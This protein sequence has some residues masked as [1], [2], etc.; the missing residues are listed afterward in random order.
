MFLINSEG[1][2]RSKTNCRIPGG[3]T[4]RP[5][6]EGNP[7]IRSRFKLRINYSLNI[8]DQRRSDIK[9]GE[10]WDEMGY[11]E[12]GCRA[13]GSKVPSTRCRTGL[14]EV[15]RM[16]TPMSV[17]G[18]MPKT[19][20]PKEMLQLRGARRG[21][22]AMGRAREDGRAPL[23]APPEASIMRCSHASPTCHPRRGEERIC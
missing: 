15:T 6:R 17:V 11:D 21:A 23:A 3:E 12:P 5:T 10:R 14:Q 8:L 18:R 4:I 19:K 22:P 9:R 7:V 1:S 20:S 13:R 2:H 16:P